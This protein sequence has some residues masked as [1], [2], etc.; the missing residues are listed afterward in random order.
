MKLNDKTTTLSLA[1]FKIE[2]QNY[3]DGY[4]LSKEQIEAIAEDS[5]TDFNWDLLAN[6]IFICMDTIIYNNY[7]EHLIQKE[8]EKLNKGEIK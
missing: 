3:L 2:A 4:G 8:G 6:E 1:D 5:F 7:Q